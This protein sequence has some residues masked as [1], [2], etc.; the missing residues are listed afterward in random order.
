MQDMMKMYSVS[1]MNPDMF[2]TET[3][4]LLNIK[5]PLVQHLIENEE[6]SEEIRYMICEQLYDLA[7]LSHTHLSPDA[8]TKFIKRSNDLLLRLI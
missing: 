2:K 1:G 7:M 6:A 4:L 5:H 3:T 8:M